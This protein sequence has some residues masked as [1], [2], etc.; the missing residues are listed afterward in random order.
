M[1]FTSLNSTLRNV[2][3]SSNS[4]LTVTYDFFDDGNHS[5]GLVVED[6]LYSTAVWNWTVTVEDVNRAPSI[7]NALENLTVNTTI[8]IQDYFNHGDQFDPHFFR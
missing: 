3:P 8:T 5:I 6:T 7:I 2:V 4:S 1:F